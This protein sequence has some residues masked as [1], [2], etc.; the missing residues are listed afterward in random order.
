[1]FR[2]RGGWVN[3]S[4]GAVCGFP[5]YHRSSGGYLQQ[6]CIFLKYILVVK[7]HIVYMG[8]KIYD[9]PDTTKKV[10]H[11]I[12]SSLLGSNK[13]GFSGFAAR[14]TKSQAE[15]VAKFSGVI[16]VIPNRIHK[17]HTTRSWNFLGIHHSS[18]NT[19]SNEINL[20]EGTIIDVFDTGIW[21]ESLS[22]NDEAMGKIPSRWKGV[23]EVEEQFSSKNF[24]TLYS[25]IHQ[26]FLTLFLVLNAF[27]ICIFLPFV[28]FILLD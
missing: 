4:V 3:S 14:L 10:R 22:F 25:V 28:C 19:V 7:V 24:S 27:F 8:D 13:H 5:C 11:K 26:T 9:N 16:F 6:K 12:L 1:M 15:E 17:L 21:P 2:P 23:C 18:S 20:G